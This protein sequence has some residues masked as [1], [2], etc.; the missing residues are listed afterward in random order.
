MFLER[1]VIRNFRAVEHADLSFGSGLNLLLGRN[2]SGKSTVLAAIRILL[3]ATL[4]RQSRMLDEGDVYGDAKF[5]GPANIVIAAKF[6]GFS[7]NAIDKRLRLRFK[8]ADGEPSEWLVYRFRPKLQART[9]I[10]DGDRDSASLQ[11][12]DYEAERLIGVSADPMTL[13]WNTDA[14]GDDLT[15]KDLA[16]IYVTEIQALRDVVDELRRQRT[17]PLADLME[18]VEVPQAEK[19]AVE[20]AYLTAQKSVEAVTALSQIASAIESS[21]GLLSSESTIELRLALTKPGYASIVQELTVLLTDDYVSDMELRRNGLGYN[22]LLYIAMLLERFRRRTESNEGTPLLLIEEPE[23]H[24]HPQAQEALLRSILSQ[25]FQTIAT[26]HSPYVAAAAGLSAII[27]L[28]RDDAVK[29]ISIARA[30]ALTIDELEDLTRFL[31]ADR[32]TILLAATVILVEGLAEQILL[33]LYALVLGHDL[34]AV[35]IQVCAIKRH[36]FFCV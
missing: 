20:A 36:L 30:T 17:S 22:N 29:G 23:A 16:S 2:G 18:T 3:D 31:N 9:E 4:G 19:D 21:Y 8:A 15:D 7:E 10:A 1:L 12:G 13:D 28:D 14:P 27:N 24:L 35:G 11:R 25:P 5:A 6:A 34:A 33:P 26:T 32:G